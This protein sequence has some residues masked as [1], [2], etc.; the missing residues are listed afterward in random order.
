MFNKKNTCP[1]IMGEKKNTSGP[2]P[3]YVKARATFQTEK[4]AGK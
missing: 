2:T 1:T 3:M 4:R